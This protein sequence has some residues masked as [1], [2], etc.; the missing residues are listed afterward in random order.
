MLH[1]K[2]SVQEEF[3]QNR[4]IMKGVYSLEHNI[5]FNIEHLRK[6]ETYF[7]VSWNF[8]RW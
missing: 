8:R 5:P 6:E 2:D 7:T 4:L 3:A 1:D